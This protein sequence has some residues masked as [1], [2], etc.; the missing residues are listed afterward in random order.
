[1]VTRRLKPDGD[2]DCA[3]AILQIRDREQQRKLAAET[4]PA[5]ERRTDRVAI[6]RVA[7]AFEK[8][9]SPSRSDDPCRCA[10]SLLKQ[11]VLGCAFGSRRPTFTNAISDSVAEVRQPVSERASVE[12]RKS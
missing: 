5:R 4:A 10:K 9:L 3:K 6:T 1:M 12:E 8:A 7:A 2:G 11:N